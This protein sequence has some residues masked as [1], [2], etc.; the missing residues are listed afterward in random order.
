[1]TPAARRTVIALMFA[2]TSVAVYFAPAEDADE[3]A[4]IAL[5]RNG[6]SSAARANAPAPQR[7]EVARR[8]REDVPSIFALPERAS[9]R[10][11]RH[12]ANPAP[13]AE[14][15]PQAPPVPFRVLGRFVENGVPG[16]FVQL[17]DRTIVA[18]NGDMISDLYK[19]ETISDQAMTVLYLPLNVT[20]TV[21][22]GGSP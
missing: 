12:A 19:V 22:T 3:A 21:N 13:V 5:P 6:R 7:A 9:P 20:Q 2:A 14:E 16:M 15:A 1:M 8:Y 10:V 18:R 11:A 17:N 4:A